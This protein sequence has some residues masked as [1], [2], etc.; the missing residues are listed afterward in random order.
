MGI[1]AGLGGFAEGAQ[2]QEKLNIAAQAEA[3][4]AKNQQT[5][6]ADTQIATTMKTIGEIAKAAAD[7]GHDP[8]T[9][10]TNGAVQSLLQSAQNLATRVGRDPNQL[11][12]MVQTMAL[13]PAAQ[14][15]D[16][17]KSI[18]TTSGGLGMPDRMHV[19]DTKKGT[20]T[21]ID[22]ATGQPAVSAP[23]PQLTQA[24]V[25]SPAQAQRVNAPVVPPGAVPSVAPVVP[26]VPQEEASIPPNAQLTEGPINSRFAEPPAPAAPVNHNVNYDAIASYSPKAQALIKGVADGTI[27]PSKAFSKRI[28]KDGESELTKFLGAVKEYD[29][30]FDTANAPARAATLKSFKSGVE[31]RKLSALG[32]V[33]GHV[34][35]LAKDGQA[36]DNWKSDTFGGATKTANQL[37]TWLQENKQSPII[38]RFDLSAT[39]VS[40]ELE[41]AFRGNTTAISG[42]QEWRKSINPTMASDEI[43]TSTQKL[44]SLLLARMG[45]LKEQWDRG[46]GHN[47]DPSIAIKLVKTRELLEKMAAGTLLSDKAV[48]PAGPG[49]P[50]LPPGFVPQ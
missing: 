29:P 23:Q 19:F 43:S 49:A 21:P 3:R 12:Q 28:G 14:D 38:R 40:N 31:A 6:D 35:E 32:T 7:A 17:K 2:A 33:V 25:I 48:H 20:L 44:G 11:A 13:R 42:I 41:N 39:A 34:A 5:A 15:A 50:P 10:L 47:Q 46:M 8:K 37:R 45:E 16:S 24:D 1:G 9:I 22:P 36:L 26:V 4:A 27:D 30:S 18:V